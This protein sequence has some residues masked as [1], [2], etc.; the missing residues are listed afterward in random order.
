MGADT[1]TR[2]VAFALMVMLFMTCF[3]L[4]GAARADA[5]GVAYC[6][7]EHGKAGDE[8]EYRTTVKYALMTRESRSE[9]KA[10]AYTEVEATL[11]QKYAHLIGRTVYEHGEEIDGPTCDTWAF[12]SG[13]WTLIETKFDNSTYTFHTIVAGVGTTP[14]AAEA[15]AIKNLRLHNWSW[16]LDDH[17]YQGLSSG[18]SGNA[19]GDLA[20]SEVD[21]P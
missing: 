1:S 9:A 6:R 17:G 18:G 10:A 7:L 13:Y 21:P 16:S 3:W 11:K 5:V 4:V 8:T 12:S 2:R 15:N 14:D 20:V 19:S